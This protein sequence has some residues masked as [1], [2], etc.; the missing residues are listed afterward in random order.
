MLRQHLGQP[1]RG[2]HLAVLVPAPDH[3]RQRLAQYGGRLLVP[4][5][6]AQDGSP[7]DP[8]LRRI[9]GHR[10]EPGGQFG[11]V[12]VGGVIGAEGR[13]AFGGLPQVLGGTWVV[14]PGQMRSQRVDGVGAPPQHRLRVGRVQLSAARGGQ[15][16]VT[17]QSHQRVAEGEAGQRPA[18]DHHRP[19]R[20]H[21]GGDRRVHGVGRLG[22]RERRMQA[23]LRHV[24]DLAQR[25][26]AAGHGDGLDD[27]ACRGPES[28][29]ASGHQLTD[30]LRGA[31]PRGVRAVLSRAGEFQGEQRITE[32]ELPDPVETGSGPRVLGDG[33]ALLASQSSQLH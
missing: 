33:Q 24:Q 29:K 30:A 31:Q 26:P 11:V 13:G 20:H 15:P 12:A 7:V 23:V 5:H 10:V 8:G 18:T 2:Q 16:V 25:G 27:P 19:F 17:G 4:G 21:R 3:V 14:G 22:G 6:P 9:G 28:R 1:G 32:R